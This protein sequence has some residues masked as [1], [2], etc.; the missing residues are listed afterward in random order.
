MPP[1]F[2]AAP[3]FLDQHNPFIRHIVRRSR[4]YLEETLDPETGEP[5]LKPIKVELFGERDE[6]AIKLPIYL[7]EAYEL[8]GEFCQKLSSR[9]KGLG[10]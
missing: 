3:R 5:Y 9:L 6:D 1:S 2:Q 4:K 8:A 7:R 10:F